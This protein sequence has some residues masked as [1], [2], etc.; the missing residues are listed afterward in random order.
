MEFVENIA[1][2]LHNTFGIECIGKLACSVYSL[3]DLR[4][5]IKHPYYM[6]STQKLILGGGS[7]ILFTQSRYEGLVIFN[8][9]HGVKMQKKDDLHTILEAGSGEIWHDIVQRS[10]H[11]GLAGLENLSLIPGTI[12]AAPMQNIGAYGVELKD[13]FEYLEAF[14]LQSGVVHRF[15]ASECRFGYRDSVFK[16]ELKNQYFITK[17]GLKLRHAQPLYKLDYGSIKEQLHSKGVDEP[18][19]ASISEAV[20][21]IRKSK[22]PDPGALGNA[23][24][25]FKNP[26]IPNSKAQ[27]IQREY[28]LAPI[29]PGTDEKSKI[30][31]GWLIEQCGFKGLRI[32]NTGAHSTQALVLVNYGGAEGAEIW[33]LALRIRQEVLSKFGIEIEPEVNVV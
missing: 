9:I 11:H 28:P 23:G 15:D 3:D 1:L 30:A 10:I 20:I 29:Y 25:F 16:N 17:V 31:A 13:V 26:L 14:H 7:N 33:A 6:S 8:K 2:K 12:G 21:Q 18:S 19:A 24:S 4:V 5:L 32:G 22:L 27:A